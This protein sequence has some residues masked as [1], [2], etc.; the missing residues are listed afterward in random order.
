MVIGKSSVQMEGTHNFQSKKKQQ[1]LT[2]TGNEIRASVNEIVVQQD[3]ASKKTMGFVDMMK[4]EMIDASTE[5]MEQS[6]LGMKSPQTKASRIMQSDEIAS[7]RQIQRETISYMLKYLREII[8]ESIYGKKQNSSFGIQLKNITGNSQGGNGVA[9]VSSSQVIASSEYYASYE[10]NENTTF[11]TKGKVVTAD[12]REIEFGVQMEMTRSFREE[13][14]ERHEIMA[15]VTPNMM[16]PLVINLNQNAAAVSDQKFLFDLDQDGILDSI[17]RLGEGSGFLALDR[18]DDGMI[19]DGSEL[20]GTKS[21]DG[22][23]DLAEYDEDGNGWI[24]EADEIFDKLLIWTKNA[25]GE[26]ELLHLKDAGIGAICLERVSTDF[27]LKS[28]KNNALNGAIRETGI[29]LY[30]NGTAGTMQHVDLAT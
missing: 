20:F 2:K 13:Y 19:N 3:A 4:T 6:M 18:N 25:Q 29:F 5:E 15:E 28:L 10:E 14:L 21:G 16:D 7:F 8:Y 22:F 27:S 9:A 1:M 11:S 24:D 30:E 12:G 17:S 26:D 23:S